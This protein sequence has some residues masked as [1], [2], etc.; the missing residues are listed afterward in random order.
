MTLL[1]AYALIAFMVGGP[2]APQVRAIMREGN[3][4]VSS[5]NLAETLDVSQRVYDLPIGRAMEILEPLLEAALA[6]LELDLAVARRAAEV[7]AEHYHRSNCPLS[8]A[9]A[10]MIASAGPGDGIATADPHVLAVAAKEGLEPLELPPQ[11]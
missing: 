6:L 10:V 3:V 9:D 1:D 11:G 4:A 2:A 5:A 7:R 8:L